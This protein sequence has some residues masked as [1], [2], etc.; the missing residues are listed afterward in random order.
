MTAET[1]TDYWAAQ[2]EDCPA[3]VLLVDDQA[4]VA[5][6]LQRAVA[7]DPGIDLHYCANPI[8]ALSV[9]NELQ[10]T[11]ILL[12]LVMPGVDGLT[13]LRKFRANPETAHTPIVV[14]STKEEGATKS[15]LFAAGANDYMVKLPDR[16][17]LLARIRYHS[18]SAWHR[19][20]R[21]EAFEALRRSQQALVA[22]NTALVSANEQLGKA[23]QAKSEFLSSLT[24]ELNTPIQSI[25]RKTERLLQGTATEPEERRFI[26]AIRHTAEGLERL[27]GD[28]RDFSRMEARKV[29]LEAIHFDL[30]EVFEELLGAME[31][32]AASKRLYLAAMIP[33][34]TP[35]LLK[36]DP[37]RLR[38]VL[39]NLIVNGLEFTQ[40]GAVCLRVTQLSETELQ[41][42]LCFEVQDT[43][44][45]IPVEVQ[46]RIFLPFCKGDEVPP[47][48]GRGAGLGLAICREL[49]ELMGGHIGL[50]STPGKGSIFR[51]TIPFIKQHNGANLPEI[52]E[53]LEP[54]RHRVLVVDSRECVRRLIENQMHY[55]GFHVSGASGA[56]D[57]LPM[58]RAPGG[59][60]FDVVLLNVPEEDASPFASKIRSEPSAVSA[61]LVLMAPEGAVDGA[62]WGFDAVLRT[63]LRKPEVLMCFLGLGKKTNPSS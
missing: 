4:L 16:L 37:E 28:V 55:F 7:D 18:T 9:A 3:L 25:L 21:N 13:L 5:A 41:A 43:G 26:G 52:E 51:F 10:P 48:D 17:E 36:G 11:V 19:I 57:A 23:T 53:E 6:A 56:E 58:L 29:K 62:P 49:V 59:L 39:A 8:E 31:G 38:Q 35:T 1:K 20:Q 60:P 27:V 2:P 12:D 54:L 14:L 40:T 44:C 34:K 61:R 42:I 46:S 15:A 32:V 63:P 22:S 30:A 24:R 45:G 33:P 47:R 50:E